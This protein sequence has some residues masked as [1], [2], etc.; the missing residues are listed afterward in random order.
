MRAIVAREGK[1]AR[2]ERLEA[3]RAARAARQTANG[4]GWSTRPDPQRK[5]A[6]PAAKTVAKVRSEAVMVSRSSWAQRHPALA[7]EERRLRD[8]RL[9]LPKRWSHKAQ[10]TPETHEHHRTKPEGALAR[11]HLSGAISADQLAW[12][13]AI[14]ETY[15]RIGADAHVK[16]ASL[17]TRIDASRNGDG[18]FYEKLEL[19]WRE[20]AFTR[21]RK[22]LDRPAKR[23]A[24]TQHAAPGGNAAIV[25][26]MIVEDVGY[27]VVAKRRC[28]G[29]L[30]AKR[31]LIDAL[32]LWARE[33]CE[34]SRE[35]DPATLA[36]AHAGIL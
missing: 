12:G 15:A 25:L 13:V 23:K 30:K 14:A 6:S 9:D 32:D 34:V 1:L 27:T 29:N 33:L 18:T 5:P 36:A 28:I 21:W 20:V 3:Q 7:A 10:G 19:V 11:M 16:T 31:M 22:A 17:E 35:I 2:A 8:R 26:E 4:A 24:P